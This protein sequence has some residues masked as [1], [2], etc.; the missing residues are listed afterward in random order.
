MYYNKPLVVVIYPLLYYT[1]Q[2]S[3]SKG[4]QALSPKGEK[5]TQQHQSCMMM[6]V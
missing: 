1:K 2:S 4:T 5:K 6:G 3:C